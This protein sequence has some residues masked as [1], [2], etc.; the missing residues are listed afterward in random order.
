M[1]AVDQIRWKEAQ[2]SEA[3]YWSK[4]SVCELLRISAEKPDFLSLLPSVLSKDLFT[5][6]DV[7]EIGVGPLGIS[8][9][10]FYPDKQQ[11]R[12]LEKVE[13][14]PQSFLENST[15][16]NETWASL[17][18]QWLSELAK[19]GQYVQM[20]GERIHYNSEF[21]TVIIYNVLDHVQDPLNIIKNAHEAL[22]PGGRIL[23]GVDCKSWLGRLRFEQVL[24]RTHKGSTVV[25]AHPH[26]FLPQHVVKMLIKGGFSKVTSFGV[27]GRFKCF[28]GG[29]FR[30]A[31]VGYKG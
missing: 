13:P 7:L 25:D 30:P 15:A 12:R 4:I 9:A 16:M 14:L 2:N 20:K 18:V 5:G 27:P 26:T 8:L 31:F 28:M 23:I 24:R 11:I 21:D 19:E 3:G 22:R 1:I 29:N 6:K 10:S 17:F